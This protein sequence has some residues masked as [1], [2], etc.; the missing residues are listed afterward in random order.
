MKGLVK[1]AFIAMTV[2]AL[3][4]ACSGNKTESTETTGDQSTMSA[5]SSTMSADSTMM[6]T[7]SATMSTD[8]AN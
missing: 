2:V 3:A 6:T 7:D 1:S 8:S 4:S 5:D